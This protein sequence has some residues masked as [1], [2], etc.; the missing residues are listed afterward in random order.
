VREGDKVAQAPNRRVDIKM[1]QKPPETTEIRPG[2][3]ILVPDDEGE[4]PKAEIVP[5]EEIPKAIIVPDD[6]IPRAEIVPDDEIPSA[7][8]VED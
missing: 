5:D 7:L 4:I 3:A 2:R 6:E 8:P 1:R